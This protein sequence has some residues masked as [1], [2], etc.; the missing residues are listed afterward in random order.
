MTL[1][2][3]TPDEQSLH[4][5][6]TLTRQAIQYVN[7]ILPSRGHILG[8]GTNDVAAAGE[9]GQPI[10]G[11][12]VPNTTSIVTGTPLTIASV[13]LTP[14]DWLLFGVISFT[15][16]TTTSITR[17]Q[18]SISDTDNTLTLGQNALHAISWP[19]FVPNSILYVRTGP[20]HLQVAAGATLIQY[21]VAEADFT[22][23]TLKAGA[24]LQALRLR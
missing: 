3:P 22:V 4:R 24:N 8:T 20:R 14:G 21:L 17:A 19:A 10:N 23:S 13:T 15:P 12:V 1:F 5:I 6:V 2:L 16:D 18:A 11:Q 9:I 7:M